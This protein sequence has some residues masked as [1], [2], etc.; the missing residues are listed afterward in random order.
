MSKSSALRYI[1]HRPEFT[2]DHWRR[3]WTAVV[4]GVGLK[5]KKTIK[6]PWAMLWT[7]AT[8]RDDPQVVPWGH[9]STQIENASERKIAVLKA[10]APAPS[11]AEQRRDVRLSKAIEDFAP[12]QI[13]ELF[14]S[15]L[16]E[17]VHDRTRDAYR[18]VGWRKLSTAREWML[19]S[20]RKGWQPKQMEARQ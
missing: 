12:D 17:H 10:S 5:T 4:T 13:L 2:C 7:V 1:R 16:Q 3:L 15:V 20:I 19:E 18:N 6:D 14:E 9:P 11:Q 8:D